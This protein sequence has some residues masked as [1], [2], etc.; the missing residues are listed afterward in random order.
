MSISWF[1][2]GALAGFTA[3]PVHQQPW[4]RVLL[5]DMRDPRITPLLA[6]K[7]GALDY[8]DE[9]RPATNDRAYFLARRALSRSLIGSIADI[10]G[11][12]VRVSYDGDGAP[13][14]DHPQGFHISLSGHGPYVMVAIAN[15]SCGVD[16]EALQE[17]AEPVAD[18]LHPK[19]LH[20]LEEF[21]GSDKSRNF[22]R[23]WTAK[24]AYL[25]SCGRGFLDDPQKICT[26]FDGDGFSIIADDDV[27]AGLHT[28]VAV[29][30]VDRTP[31]MA[32]CILVG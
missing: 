5:A 31:V 30:N 23:I 28:C 25:K 29:K 10:K 16:F 20:W 15:R 4:C 8:R 7:P 14:V 24:E 18:V 26:S 9:V 11:D 32:A 22:L 2:A 6:P 19:E 1:D 13:R 17:D 12:D 27:I 3:T 21:S